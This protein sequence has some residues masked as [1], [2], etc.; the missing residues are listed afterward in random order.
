MPVTWFFAPYE[1]VVAHLPA[2]KCAMDD[3]TP[4]ITADGGGWSEAEVLGDQ[5]VVKLNAS[6]ATIQAVVADGRFQRIPAAIR[7][8]DDP[9]STLS[10]GQ[11][12]AIRDKVLALG[13]TAQE[14]TNALGDLS[15]ATLRD[16]LHLICK[17]RF[18][19]RWDGQ[20]FV[21]DGAQQVC[22]TPEA[23]DSEV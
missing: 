13:Y 3:F 14:V 7:L 4:Q 9:L 6:T 5:A 8:L 12:S 2:R 22:K 11:R 10:A 15:T 19:P 16:L 17:R 1:T 23:L 20:Q 21:F 18:S